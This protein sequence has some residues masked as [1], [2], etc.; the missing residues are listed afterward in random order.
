MAAA[1]F[2]NGVSRVLAFDHF[3]FVNVDLIVHLDREPEGEWVLL[4]ARTSIAPQ[5]TGLATASP[6]NLS[7]PIG[8]AAQSLLVAER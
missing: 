6:S 8:V 1:D 3:L 5:G 4:D 2:A 7:G